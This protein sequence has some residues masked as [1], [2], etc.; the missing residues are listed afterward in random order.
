MTQRE[1]RLAIIV[2]ALLVVLSVSFISWRIYNA[3]AVRSARWQAAMTQQNDTNRKITFG[4]RAGRILQQ[5]ADTALP[6]DQDAART[7]Y[8]AWLM[9]VVDEIKLKNPK[10]TPQAV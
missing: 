4:K 6:A 5:Y 2:G 1:K 3:F 9:N 7:M 10:V 8:K